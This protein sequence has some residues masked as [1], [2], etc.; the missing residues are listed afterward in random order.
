MAMKQI[1]KVDAQHA[2]A[3]LH[4]SYVIISQNELD[5]TLRSPLEI[6]LSLSLTR[7][8]GKVTGNEHWGRP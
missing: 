5:S 6:N 1:Q 4:F 2:V 8:L 7:F 3:G